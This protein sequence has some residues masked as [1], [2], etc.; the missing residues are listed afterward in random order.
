M[1]FL[2][3]LYYRNVLFVLYLKR[4]GEIIEEIEVEIVTEKVYRKNKE[5][6]AVGAIVTIGTETPKV[7]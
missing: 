5:Y 1:Y 2:C 7:N 4:I 3:C 6:F